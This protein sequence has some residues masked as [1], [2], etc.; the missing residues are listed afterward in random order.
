MDTLISHKE[1]QVALKALLLHM[2]HSRNYFPVNYEYIFL[3]EQEHNSKL[4]L[5]KQFK[6]H[7]E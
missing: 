5:Y 7:Q 1:L 4:K 6:I 3:K 2:L